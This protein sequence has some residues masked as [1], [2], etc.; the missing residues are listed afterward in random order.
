MKQNI[1]FPGNMTT[2][3]YFKLNYVRKKPLKGWDDIEP[4]LNNSNFIPELKKL[5]LNV[6]DFILLFVNV[7]YDEWYFLN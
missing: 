4:E 6:Y 1:I 7:F 5:Y 2:S 3:K